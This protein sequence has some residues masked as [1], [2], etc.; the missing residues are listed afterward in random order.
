MASQKSKKERNQVMTIKTTFTRK[1]FFQFS[2]LCWAICLNTALLLVPVS[3]ASVF[4]CLTGAGNV[5]FTD[6]PAQLHSCNKLS[7]YLSEEEVK[8]E[9]S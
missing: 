9:K 2:F 7:F 4:Q 6:S 1:Q 5:I 3:A 8:S